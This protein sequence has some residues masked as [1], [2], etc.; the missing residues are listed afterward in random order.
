MWRD[1]AAENGGFAP[2]PSSATLLGAVVNAIS[3]PASSVA[4]LPSERRRR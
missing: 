3:V 4:P 2:L 1:S